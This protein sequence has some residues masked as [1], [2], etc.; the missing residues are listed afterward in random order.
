MEMV[1]INANTL[2][3]EPENC[4]SGTRNMQRGLAKFRAQSSHPI[5]TIIASQLEALLIIAEEHPDSA[6]DAA[7]HNAVASLFGEL[8]LT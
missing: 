6:V 8:E 3:S 1:T 2:L 5:N 7:I 4:D